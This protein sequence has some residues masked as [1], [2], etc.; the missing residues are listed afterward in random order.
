MVA[1]LLLKPAPTA[2]E[3]SAIRSSKENKG[4][5]AFVLEFRRHDNGILPRQHGALLVLVVLK[6]LGEWKLGVS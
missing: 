3:S 1:K 2:A 6:A 5:G 4:V